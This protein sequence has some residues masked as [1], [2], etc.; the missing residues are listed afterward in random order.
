MIDKDLT[1]GELVDNLDF[2]PG[3]VVML[4]SSGPEMTVR[5]VGIYRGDV[6]CEWFVEGIRQLEVFAQDQLM[7]HR[8][9][10]DECND[11]ED[12]EHER[13]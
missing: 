11:D 1:V 12:Y 9:D 10:C 4:V 13:N 3:Q 7:A 5:D 2:F 8:C 6:L